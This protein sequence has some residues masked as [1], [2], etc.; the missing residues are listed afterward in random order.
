[1]SINGGFSFSGVAQ[2]SDWIS[3]IPWNE[4]AI[5][6]Y[7]ITLILMDRYNVIR[8]GKTDDE[9]RAEIGISRNMSGSDD[10]VTDED[11]QKY[12]SLLTDSRM[13]EDWEQARIYLDQALNG[14]GNANEA[15]NKL[16]QAV[17]LMHEQADKGRRF[18]PA[19]SPP[20]NIFVA[21]DNN[22][23]TINYVAPS[24]DTLVLEAARE[25]QEETE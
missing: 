23:I 7:H 22:T 21:G 11:L 16:R 20:S 25:E 24:E 15:R 17:K 14:K 9:A 1:M 19:L 8:A 6:T 2:G 18:Y 3:V 5:A 13:E 4:I 12:L 10:P